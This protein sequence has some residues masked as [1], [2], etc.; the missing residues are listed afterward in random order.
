MNLERASERAYSAPG[1]KSAA[2]LY[3]EIEY[4][5]ALG[6]RTR[7]SLGERRRAGAS[8]VGGPFPGRTGCGPRDRGA[9]GPV[10]SGR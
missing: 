5:L 7:R 8:T 1:R 2:R 3:N 6:E 10:A 9:A 4:E